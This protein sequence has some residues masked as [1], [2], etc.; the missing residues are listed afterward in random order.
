[1][2][3]I[4]YCALLA[5]V[6]LCN[7]VSISAQDRPNRGNFDPAQFRERMMSRVRETMDV[8]DE[9]EW[10]LISDRVSKVMEAQ[11]DVRQGANMGA[12]FR[13]PGGDQNAQGG[14]ANGGNRRRGGGGPGGF[15]GEPS[16]EAEA[17]NKAL[18]SKG[19]NDDVKAAL[20]KYRESRKAKQEK[21]AKAQEDLKKVL[22]SRQEAA[23]VSLGLLE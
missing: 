15:G 4:R 22:S 10:K 6:A 8:K 1:M 2:K 13:R 23:A 7:L 17:L 21:L 18:E 14:D 19:S 12:M 9:A 16:P 11:R 5:V 20:A 3:S